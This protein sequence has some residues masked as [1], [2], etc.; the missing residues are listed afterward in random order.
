MDKIK[1]RNL[2]IISLCGVLLCMAVGYAA[3]QTVLNI[4]GVTTITTKWNVL[5]TNITSKDIK[6]GA[7]DITPPTHTEL[8]AT[9]K[10][11]LTKPGD[12]IT[13]DI[14]VENQ[15]SFDAY[16]NKITINKTK[17]N[18]AI[19][20]ESSGLQE[21]DILHPKDVKV[22]T[23]VVTFNNDITDEP[24]DKSADFTVELDVSQDPSEKPAE[25]E[26]VWQCPEGYT[27][28]DEAG[29]DMRCSKTI[30]KKAT[31]TTTCDC[32]SGYSKSG[33]GCDI[34]CSTTSYSSSSST[35]CSAGYECMGKCYSG[36]GVL[37]FYS[38]RYTNCGGTMSDFCTASNSC[39]T[40]GCRCY[41]GSIGSPVPQC[42]TGTWNGSQCVT[43]RTTNKIQTT[44]YSCD[45]GYTSHGNGSSMTCTRTEEASPQQVT[46][47]TCPDGYHLQDQTCY[48][49]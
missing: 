3:F 38:M 4:N 21:G 37:D 11:G 13:Y 23:I 2:V 33:N 24:E 31:E 46:T 34:T 7:Y 36:E 30:E 18:E 44:T 40:H 41:Y 35:K 48:K 17:E 14:A 27:S 1:K 6:G 42:T 43:T 32:P 22:L 26:L 15:G 12:S 45:S 10:T 9:F 19:L 29:P 28:T 20:F 49:D 39:R 8:E 47:Y 5:I 16:L 25:S